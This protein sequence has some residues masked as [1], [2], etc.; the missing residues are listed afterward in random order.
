MLLRK[1]GWEFFGGFLVAL[2]GLQSSVLLLVGGIKNS[3]EIAH[4][5]PIENRLLI[6]GI[7]NNYFSMIQILKALH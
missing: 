3:S 4:K 5:K 6:L 2:A 1:L 7:Q